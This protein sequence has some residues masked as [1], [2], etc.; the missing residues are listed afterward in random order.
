MTEKRNPIVFPSNSFDYFLLHTRAGSNTIFVQIYID[1]LPGVPGVSKKPDS[2]LQIKLSS[3][4]ANIAQ[5]KQKVQ[6]IIKIEKK[7]QKNPVFLDILEYSSIWRQ[8]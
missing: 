8:S 2:F 4:C 1:A 7:G 6:K 5:K 3:L